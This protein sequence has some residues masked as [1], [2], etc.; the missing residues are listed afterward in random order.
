LAFAHP[1]DRRALAFES[2]LPPDLRR[3]WQQ[4]LSP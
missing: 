2:P 3:A 1:I 4:G